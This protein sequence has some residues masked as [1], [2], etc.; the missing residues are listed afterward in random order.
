MIPIA[1]AA[2]FCYNRQAMSTT[3]ARILLVAVFVARGTSFLFSK[4]LLQSMSPLSILAVRFILAFLILA[5]LFHKKLLHCDRNSFRGG[6]IL[7][8]LYTICMIFEMFG[9]RTVDTGVSSLVENMAIIMVPVFTA[10]LTRT[11]PKKI[12]MFC[13]LLAVIGVG[14]LSLTQ[15]SS[16]GSHAGMILTVLA[17]LTYAVCIMATEKVSRDAEPVTIGI[18]QLGTMGVLSLIASLIAGDFGL[19][20]TGRQWILL[21][22]LVLLCSCFGFAFQPLGQKYVAAEEAAVLTV[23]N[24]L[25]ASLMG[26]LI[27]GEILSPMKIAGYVLILA[28]LLLYNLKTVQHG[29]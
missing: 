29:H 27:A 25:T 19:P 3:N 15:H 20:Q 5:V 9:L 10:V 6:V 18:I 26:I 13:A 21:M 17:A 7:G 2:S 22:L 8:V 12:T 16:G 4:T 14:F 11:L 24:P 23:V 1:A 28:A